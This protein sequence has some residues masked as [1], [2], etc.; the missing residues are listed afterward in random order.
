MRGAVGAYLATAE[1]QATDYWNFN[2]G[3]LKPHGH[4]ATR[5]HG[6]TPTARS[7]C[8]LIF[9]ALG[10]ISCSFSNASSVLLAQHMHICIDNDKFTLF[11]KLLLHRLMLVP[12]SVVSLLTASII[13]ICFSARTLPI[14]STFSTRGVD[15]KSCGRAYC[16]SL[17]TF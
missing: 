16:R 8:G 14:A 10:S 17:L 12:I 1:D 3:G 13:H 15:K 6:H 4:T 2:C 11:G 7:K 5:P 9:A